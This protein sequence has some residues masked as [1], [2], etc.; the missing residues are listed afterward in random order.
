MAFH[1]ACHAAAS[2]LTG[3]NWTEAV[4]LKSKRKWGYGHM[5]YSLA[6]E[7]TEYALIATAGALGENLWRMRRLEGAVGVPDHGASDQDIQIVL[8]LGRDWQEET[9]RATDLL[10][11]HEDLVA[12]I[13]RSLIRHERIDA[14]FVRRR[15][16]KKLS[17][18]II[19]QALR[20]AIP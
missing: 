14:A 1:E 8:E 13:A 7:S 2:L 17:S 10:V 12:W 4:L 16:P 18:P 11:G 20:R 19:Q 15:L 9:N 3:S 6:A 5:G